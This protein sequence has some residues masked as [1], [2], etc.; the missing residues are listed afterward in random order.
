MPKLEKL[1]KNKTLLFTLLACLTLPIIVSGCDDTNYQEQIAQSQLTKSAQIQTGMPNILNFTEKKL[2][3]HLYEIRDE[4]LT[5]FTYYIDM[6][7]RKHL[8]CKSIGFGLPYATQYSNPEKYNYNGNNLPQAEPNGL[9]MPSSA[10]STWV[11]CISPKGTIEPVYS[12]E[13]LTISTFK[14]GE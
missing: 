14:L 1:M 8:L 3:K 9:F 4:K 7:G 11:Q 10:E 13:R 6:Q 2:M 12:E 5:T